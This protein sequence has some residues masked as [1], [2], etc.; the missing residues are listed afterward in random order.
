MDGILICSM[1]LLIILIKKQRNFYRL[2][3]LKPEKRDTM[4]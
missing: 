3:Q 1:E 4:T 2:F